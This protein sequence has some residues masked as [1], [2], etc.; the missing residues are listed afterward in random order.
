MRNADQ[1]ASPGRGPGEP[2]G[3]QA[4]PAPLAPATFESL[5]ELLHVETGI[6][7]APRKLTM[8][9]SRL[10]KRLRALGL[11]SFDDYLDQLQTHPQGEE[12]SNFIN[13][14][15]TNLTRFFREEHHF[16]KLVSWL[17]GLRPLPRP[18]RVWS[19]GCST[20][21]E[22]YSIAMSLRR[23]FPA[24]DLRI[25]ATDLDSEVLKVAMA[26]IYDRE[27]VKDLDPELLRFAFL[28]GRG[29]QDGCVRV[30][31]DLRGLVAFSQFNLLQP[32]WPKVGGYE[33][34]FCRNV[35][36]YFDPATQRELI[37][38]FHRTLAPWGL[39]FVGHSESLLDP[40]L[41]FEPLG[42]TAFQRRAR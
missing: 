24:A 4:H 20:G 40:S 2:R 14:L 16:Q 22:P 6:F 8:V 25:L 11:T 42:R 7:L 13:A 15:T 17:Q 31:E 18:I 10:N 39:L 28:R 33:A 34:V 12:A 27:R 41:G 35:M 21:E 19:A 38:R 26:G 1:L 32:D 3:T 5:R 29:G 36:I 30:R 37:G 23:A 9:Q